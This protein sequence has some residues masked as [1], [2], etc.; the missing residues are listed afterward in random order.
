MESLLLTIDFH[1]PLMLGIAY[2]AGF[3][4]SRIGLPP[5]VGFLAAGFAFGAMGAVNTPL[6]SELADL[7]VTL[8]LFS[9]GLKLRVSSLLKPEIWG[10]ATLHML[11]TVIVFGAILLGMGA[12]GMSLFAQLD[13]QTAAIV[14]FALSFSSTVFAVKALEATGQSGSRCGRIAI[15]V[16][17]I[18]DIA[19]VIFLAASSGKL[20]SLWAFSLP[21]LLLL[22]KPVLALLKKSGHGELLILFGFV[23]ALGGAQLFEAFN[24]K[25]DLGAL[26]I[27]AVIA[28]HPRS[29]ELATTLLSFKELFLVAFFLSIGL[30]GLPTGEIFFTGLVLL[31]LVPLKITLFF[32]LFTRFRLRATTANRSSLVLAN[33]SEF[34]L[35]VAAIAV[36]V[37][38]LPTEWMLVDAVALSLSFVFASVI[39]ANTNQIF[40]RLRK[41]LESFEHPQRLSED[42]IIDLGHTRMIIFGMGRVGTGVYD[43]MN[44]LMPGS[45]LGVDY[46]NLVIEKHRKRGRNVVTGNA[47]NPEFWDRVNMSHKVEYAMLVMPDHNAQVAAIKQTRKH[48]FKGKIAASAKYPDELEKLKELGVDAA[49][50]IYA[51]VGAGFASLAS[52]KFGLAASQ[53][54]ND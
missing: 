38:W 22:R 19:A 16:L 20:P 51:E 18:Q 30:A 52:S 8:L 10:V 28:G 54:D 48:G 25:G 4:F 14:A 13:L 47:A 21:G 36:S 34:G 12:T 27:G 53:I 44:K 1:D 46:D 3:V 17:I 24:L 31:L 41:F 35:I 6:L 29:D 5:L 45:V 11:I 2:I 23:L 37:G 39:S 43:A 33:Y 42:A 26:F 40:S 32:W 15:G 7:G 9:I 49:F 50:N